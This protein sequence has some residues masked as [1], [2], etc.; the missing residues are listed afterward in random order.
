MFAFWALVTLGL[1]ARP[2]R[3]QQISIAAWT[4]ATLVYN[5][6]F[7]IKPATEFSN[8]RGLVESE[9][10][11]I[12]VPPEGWVLVNNIGAVYIP[13]FAGRRPVNLRY[14]ANETVLRAKLDELNKNGQSVFVSGLTLQEDGLRDALE[15]YGLKPVAQTAGLSMYRVARLK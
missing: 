3:W 8:N 5:F 6:V 10:T 12:S 9:W 11:K 4:A 15:R 7:V 2:P 13:Y 1:Q 14:Y